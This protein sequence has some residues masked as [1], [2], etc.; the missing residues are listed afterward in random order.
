MT[1]IP[2]IDLMDGK[3]V[4]LTQGAF[5]TSIVYSSDPVE[6][7]ETFASAG[8]NWLHL[9][10]LDG[11]RTGSP[12][13][14][15]VLTSIKSQTDLKV[16][17]GGGLR[18]RA[19]VARAFEHGADLVTIGSAAI[20]QPS[21][22]VEWLREFGP[23]R[24]IL[25]ADVKDGYIA[26]SGWMETSTQPLADTIAGFANFGLKNVMITDVSKDGTLEGPATDLY[27]DVKAK[28]PDLFVI[29]S[30]GV[31]SIEDLS[32]LRATG[33]DAAIV[34]KAFYEGKIHPGDLAYRSPST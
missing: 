9:V 31:G 18:D 33:C 32:D 3:C 2:A 34:G 11:A 27:S 26:L 1:V 24:I 30:G 21:H 6:M 25:A 16:D 19:A 29:A 13:H 8:L 22:F 12:E 28:F 4:R 23:D 17:F 7:A 20:R 15:N 10:D 14:L 5:E